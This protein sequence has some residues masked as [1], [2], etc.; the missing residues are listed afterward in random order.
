LSGVLLQRQV[1]A[2]AEVFVGVTSD[3]TF[4]P[5]LACGIGGTLVELVH[6]V[7][8][9]LPPVSDR[10]AAEMVERLRCRPLLEGYR[11][12]PAADRAAFEGLICRIAALLDVVPEL[13]ELD[14]NPVMLRAAGGGAVVV[15]ARMR[16]LA[17]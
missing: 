7:S 14:L 8:L 17:A 1:E 16:L 10:D 6:D 12:R 11:G 15:D 5:L 4:G 2:A 9:R 3:A 13:V